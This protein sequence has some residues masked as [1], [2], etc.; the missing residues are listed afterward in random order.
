DYTLS[1]NGKDESEIIWGR[2]VSDSASPSIMVV[3][4]TSAPEGITYSAKAADFAWGLVAAVMPKFHDSATGAPEIS[5]V[6]EVVDQSWVSDIPESVLTTDFHEIP[7]VNRHPGVPGVWSFDVFKPFDTA[8]VEWQ[9]VEGPGWYYGKGFDASTGIGLVQNEKGAR[10]SYIPARD[11]CRDMMVSII[12]EPGK[13][14]GQGFGSATTQYMDICVKFDPVSL[15]GYALR[16]ERTPDH[17]RAVSFSL[18]KYDKGK[19]ARISEEEISDCYRTPCHINVGIADGV[20][21]AS[22]Y[23]DASLPDRK[24]CDEVVDK[25]E[26]SVPVESGTSTGFCIQHTGS[27]GPSSTLLRDLDIHWD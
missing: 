11:V 8:H 22:A 6:V 9:A 24:C 17:D 18:I 4:K 1:G 7:I 20:L 3:R 13:S 23:T 15:D 21:H 5:P 2:V 25:V 16:I 27:T 10:M 26:L 14:G 19:T 12:A